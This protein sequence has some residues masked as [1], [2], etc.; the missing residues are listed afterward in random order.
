MKTLITVFLALALCGCES[1]KKLTDIGEGIK[2]VAQ[3]NENAPPPQSNVRRVDCCEDPMLPGTA[4]F[5][6]MLR[7]DSDHTIEAGGIVYQADCFRSD[8]P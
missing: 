4:I 5:C 1:A 6:S 2:D 7:D 8:L 3:G